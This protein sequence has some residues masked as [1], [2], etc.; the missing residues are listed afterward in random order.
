MTNE[1]EQAKC[2]HRTRGLRK[3][4]HRWS[5]P[6]TT[7]HRVIDVEWSFV[8]DASDVQR[9]STEVNSTPAPIRLRPPTSLI[10]RGVGLTTRHGRRTRRAILGRRLTQPSVRAHQRDGPLDAVTCGVPIRPPPER[11]P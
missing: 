8:E 11:H 10:L 7:P 2:V 4:L 3:D 1:N 6:E 9:A 5:H